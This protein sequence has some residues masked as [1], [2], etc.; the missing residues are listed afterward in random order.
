MKTFPLDEPRPMGHEAERHA[1]KISLEFRKTADLIKRL[2]GETTGA[3]SGGMLTNGG[4]LYIDIGN[5]VEHAG[6]ECT[7]ATGIAETYHAGEALSRAVIAAIA[8]YEEEPDADLFSRTYDS[9]GNAKGFHENYMI[10]T[11]HSLGQLGNLLLPHLVSR[12]VIFGS[13]LLLPEPSDSGVRFVIAQKVWDLGNNV[14]SVSSTRTKAKPFVIGRQESFD[15]SKESKRLQISS[16]DLNRFTAPVVGRF[17]STSLLLRMI[18]AD[19][20][21]LPCIIEQPP[22]A[23]ARIIASDPSLQ[24]SIQVTKDGKRQYLSGL[25]IQ[26]DLADKAAAFAEKNDAIPEDERV[27]AQTWI[28]LV[29]DLLDGQNDK[30]LD[31]VE[32][33]HK[34]HWLSRLMEKHD[35]TLDDPYIQA[36]EI[37]WHRLSPDGYVARL[38]KYGRMAMFPPVDRLERTMIKPP[39]ATRAQGR[40]RYLRKRAKSDAAHMASVSATWS[41]WDGAHHPDA[42]K[43][44][45]S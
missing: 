22:G 35:L 20:Y 41:Y 17:M 33:L 15:E 27:Y 14:T 38:Q 40:S 30:H 24:Q 11:N 12:E 26:Y 5:S 4:R 43:T 9:A 36:Q 25:Q 21:S 39:D 23:A 31:K 8:E 6:A 42:R 10:G 45:L 16:G 7:T 2:P 28:S 44:Y 37:L 29:S 19:K 1:S 34:W 32:H 3:Y 18:E 13:G